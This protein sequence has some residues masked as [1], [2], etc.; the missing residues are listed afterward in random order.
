VGPSYTGTGIESRA[1]AWARFDNYQYPNFRNFRT[2]V[3]LRF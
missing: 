2:M 3:E 1:S